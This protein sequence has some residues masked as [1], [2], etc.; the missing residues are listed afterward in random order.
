MNLKSIF[1][2]LFTAL[3][4]LISI[5]LQGEIR[6]RADFGVAYL[7]VDILESGKTI[8]TL[9]M[10][11]VK[12]DA[13]ILVYQGL[14]IKPNF[15]FGWGH[16][17]L[18]S[19][20]VAVGYYIPMEY[21]IPMCKNFSIL[22]NVGI[23]FSYLSTHVSFEELEL[24][25]LKERFRSSSPYIGMDFSYTFLEVW[26]IFGTYQ[27][28]WSGTHT[29]IAKLGSQKSHSCGPNYN[30]GI[31]YAITPKWGVNFGVGYNITLSKEKHGLR[32]KGAKLGM[33]Y[34][35]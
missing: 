18:S 1:F 31:E 20:G 28:A 9:Y 10:R 15:L 19:G 30:L 13:T 29:K 26:S 3:F 4:C 7:A 11:G 2:R 12:G 21:F 6:G 25:H 16:G 22:P 17:E 23:A 8:E 27:Y 5:S 24:F 33:A 14:A 32:G 35:F 34:Y